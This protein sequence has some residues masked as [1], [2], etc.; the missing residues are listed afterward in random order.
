MA[1]AHTNTHTHNS[2]ARSVWLLHWPHCSENCYTLTQTA[3]PLGCGPPFSLRLA[4]FHWRPAC[5]RRRRRRV[6]GSPPRG[7]TLT[8]SC[9][10]ALCGRRHGKP[11]PLS[12]SAAST[13]PGLDAALGIALNPRGRWRRFR[14]KAPP[15]VDVITKTVGR[16]R[17]TPTSQ[18]SESDVAAHEFRV[19]HP[20]HKIQKVMSPH[21]SSV[22]PTHLSNLRK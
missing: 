22:K 16:F 2:L 20:H 11:A 14:N 17:D 3:A 8:W 21:T 12:C 6:A 18:S 1:T 10:S 7:E 19:T 13:P 5:F 9:P 15:Q 4:R